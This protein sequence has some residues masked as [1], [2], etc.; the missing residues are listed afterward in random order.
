VF[1]P[2]PIDT[3]LVCPITVAECASFPDLIASPFFFSPLLF[4][5]AKL[6]V[7]GFACGSIE[8][9]S[10]ENGETQD[11]T[12]FHEG[13]I[14]ALQ[15]VDSLKKPQS[16]RSDYADHVADVT[17]PLWE[18]PERSSYLIHSTT[19]SS[20]QSNNQNHLTW[21]WWTVLLFCGCEQ[22]WEQKAALDSSD[23]PFRC[24]L[25]SLAQRGRQ[26]VDN[27]QVCIRE[28]QTLSFQ[29]LNVFFPSQADENELILPNVQRFRS[30]SVA[31]TLFTR[32]HLKGSS[33]AG[34][35]V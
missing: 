33:H 24:R 26:W 35:D 21:S 2:P 28:Q 34:M 23:F 4:S 19:H 5:T 22:D 9:L 13:P 8:I 14:R 7:V 29:V 12:M 31:K 30:Y 1:P 3:T 16:L 27:N 18:A 6:V 20:F 17:L 25:F 15:W 11:S 10:V 32:S